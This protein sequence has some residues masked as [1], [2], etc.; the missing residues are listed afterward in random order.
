ME[1]HL[2]GKQVEDIKIYV[3]HVLYECAQAANQQRD[4]E[5]YPHYYMEHRS[6]S[7]H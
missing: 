4:Q 1:C 7:V 3:E 5:I 2:C 6:S